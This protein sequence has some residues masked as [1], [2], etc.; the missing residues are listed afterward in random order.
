M[1]RQ[2]S[3]NVLEFR[4][5]SSDSYP[6]LKSLSV[7]F[8]QLKSLNVEFRQLSLDSCLKMCWNVRFFS[9][10]LSWCKSLQ[11]ERAVWGKRRNLQRV[12]YSPAA[13]ADVLRSGG[14][15]GCRF[16]W[17]FFKVSHS[18][19]T[20]DLKYLSVQIYQFS[21]KV[22]WVTGIPFTQLKT[23]V[24]LWGLPWKYVWCV[25]ELLWKGVR[26]FGSRDSFKPDLL[27]R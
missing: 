10:F 25:W 23:C 17:V 11:E 8:R 21:G 13:F 18:R 4:H 3:S 5:L 12:P 16:L 20:L 14:V 9:F 26:Y 19:R 2:L 22:F 7:E 1:L 15:L 27:R 6:K 24:E